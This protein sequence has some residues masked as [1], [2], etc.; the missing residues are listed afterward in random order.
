MKTVLDSLKEPSLNSRVIYK[1]IPKRKVTFD[2]IE[3]NFERALNLMHKLLYIPAF[4]YRMESDK[5]GADVLVAHH[6]ADV[7]HEENLNMDEELK[8]EVG[9]RIR[10]PAGAKMLTV[11]QYEKKTVKS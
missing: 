8:Q 10:S 6:G 4:G 3:A 9:A 1:N 11:D 5:E 7:V 2:Q